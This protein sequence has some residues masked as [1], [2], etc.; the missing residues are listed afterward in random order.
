MSVPPAGADASPQ[1]MLIRGARRSS[2]R[3]SAS[4]A[5]G[6][7]APA[8]RIANSSPPRR[9][10]VSVGRS[11]PPM[12]LDDP[13]EEL[14]AR[15]VAVGVV[16][17]LEAVEVEHDQAGGDPEPRHPGHRP[18]RGALEPAAVERSGERVG[19]RGDRE[20]LPPALVVA[21]LPDA[22]E[23]DAREAGGEQQRGA[24]RRARSDRQAGV[25]HDR[26][27]AH[28][29]D[30]KERIGDA[31][32]DARDEQDEGERAVGAAVEGREPEDQA[33]V[34]EAP[35]QEEGLAPARA[36]HLLP[37]ERQRECAADR[38]GNEE[39][40]QRRPVAAV[41]P[42]G[43][44]AGTRRAD[45]EGDPGS[46]GHGVL[47]EAQLGRVERVVER[48]RGG[49]VPPSVPPREGRWQCAVR[50]FCGESR[51]DG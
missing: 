13:A 22:H 10:I 28:G 50:P 23:R 32:E 31:G 29:D 49:H 16:E 44:V 40:P 4:L 33:E 20:Q 43:E 12:Q 9:A 21:G 27:R 38:A 15:R 7:S 8:S 46:R 48:L 1:E 51:L 5:A 17:V 2:M 42:P 19:A 39:R 47:P 36:D 35:G 24:A 45:D 18:A 6:A 37:R 26:R 30:R 25:S 34:E 11:S 3:L 41:A 14:V